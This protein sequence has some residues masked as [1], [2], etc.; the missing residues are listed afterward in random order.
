MKRA[1]QLIIISLGIL[2]MLACEGCT[3]F[4]AE[5]YP[6]AANMPAEVIE[7]T[8]AMRVAVPAPLGALPVRAKAPEMPRIDGLEQVENTF[9]EYGVAL[10]K[11]YDSYANAPSVSTRFTFTDEDQDAVSLALITG[12]NVDA[13][14]STDWSASPGL[15]SIYGQLN[16]QRLS[17]NGSFQPQLYGAELSLAAPDSITGL[18]FDIGLV[19]SASFASEGEF[20]V[21]RVGA[22][23]RLGQ[24]IDQRGNTEG[25]PSWYFFAGADGEAVIFNNRTAN[26]FGLGLIDG[27]QLRDQVTVGD[28]QAGLNVRRYGT[29]FAFNY[30]RREVEYDIGSETIERNEDFGGITLTWRR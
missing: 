17:L 15:R 4:V 1:R 29:N 28:I 14:E 18:G 11:T 26:G 3:A 10:P 12:F 21:R 22:E 30:I 20:S 2:S 6:V 27:I 8:H 19:P 16:A 9:R 13:V 25:L 24:D 5:D 23:F 7:T